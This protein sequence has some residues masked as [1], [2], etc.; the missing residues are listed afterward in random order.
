MSAEQ[1]PLPRPA[2]PT[3][4]TDLDPR[5][6]RFFE[7]FNHRQ[8]FEAHEVLEELWLLERGTPRD[9]FYKGLIQLAGAFVHVQKN[10]PAPAAALFRLAKS[11]LISYI[12]VYQ[13]LT[14]QPVLDMISTWLLRMEEADQ[15]GSAEFL[16]PTRIEFNGLHK[17]TS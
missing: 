4:P 14:L 7:C 11:N 16:E 5:Y 6:V 2:G 9:L 12:P 3:H 13:H 15:P 8:Y 17:A 1:H 10:R